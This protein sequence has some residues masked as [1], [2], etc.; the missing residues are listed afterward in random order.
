MKTSQPVVIYWDSSAVLS[1]LFKDQHSGKALAFAKKE[2]LHLIS[3]LGFA[4]VYA[5]IARLGREGFLADILIQAACEVLETGPWRRIFVSPQ[6]ELLKVLPRRWPLRGADLWHL[7]MAVTLKKEIP[8]L[9]LLSFDN[10]LNA[11]GTGEKLS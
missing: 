8:E 10:R 2:G 1:V 9:F 7:A 5:V 6:W 11:A 4:E 3:S